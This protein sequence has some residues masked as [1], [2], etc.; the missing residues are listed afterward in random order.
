MREGKGGTPT[1]MHN[2]STPPGG[3]SSTARA[4]I[5]YGRVPMAYYLCKVQLVFCFDT[6]SLHFIST[7]IKLMTYFGANVNSVV[8]DQMS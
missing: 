3:H 1:H 7:G 6:F 5:L 8:V 4:A 2:A